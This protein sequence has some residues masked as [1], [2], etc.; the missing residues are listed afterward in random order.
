MPLSPSSDLHPCDSR[1][2]AIIPRLE[3]SA[4][5][6]IRCFW[7]ADAPNDL[8][9]PIVRH[10][11]EEQGV[12]IRLDQRIKFVFKFIEQILFV[13]RWKSIFDQL[14]TMNQHGEMPGK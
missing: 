12:T 7:V 5:H 4:Q 3:N 13:R 6:G 1:I 14:R 9:V 2:R 8:S 11:G 10:A